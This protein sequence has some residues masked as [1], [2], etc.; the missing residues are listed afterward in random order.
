MITVKYPTGRTEHRDYVAISGVSPPLGPRQ[1][2]G[3]SATIELLSVGVEI[4]RETAPDT[5]SSTIYPWNV[6]LSLDLGPISNESVTL[7]EGRE[8]SWIRS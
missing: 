1:S 7:R 6:I 8:A 4:T 3:D 5:I 2:I